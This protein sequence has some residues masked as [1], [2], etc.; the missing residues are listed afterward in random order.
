MGS[1][2][3]VTPFFSSASLEVPGAG[4]D[5]R[6]NGKKSSW[7][8]ACDISRIVSLFFHPALNLP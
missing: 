7:V 5:A 4:G 6:F 1:Y 3:I 8:V 2:K